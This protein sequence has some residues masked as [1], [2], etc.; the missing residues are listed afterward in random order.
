MQV[1]LLLLELMK[2]YKQ[3][4]ERAEE[5]ASTFAGKCNNV[6]FVKHGDGSK[7]E[8]THAIAYVESKWIMIFTEHHGV[9]VYNKEDLTEC[10]EMKEDRTL[11][12]LV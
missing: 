8:Y 7:L 2:T 4:K 9:H 5:I 12:Y 6:V 3:A 11:L 10:W 1:R